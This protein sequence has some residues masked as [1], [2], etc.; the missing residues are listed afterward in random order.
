MVFTAPP[1]A[2]LDHVGSSLTNR[3]KVPLPDVVR[4]QTRQPNLAGAGEISLR[5]LVREA[6]RM[7]P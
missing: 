2:A 1:G 3:L 6:L 7:R 4:M 5:H